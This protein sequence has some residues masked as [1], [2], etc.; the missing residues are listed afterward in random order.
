VA[1][2]I[3]VLMLLTLSIKAQGNNTWWKH[4]TLITSGI[5]A[6]VADGQREVIVHNKWAYRHRHPNARESWWNPDSTWKRQNQRGWVVSGP[7]AFTQDKYHLNQ[8]IRTTMFSIQTGM[9]VSLSLDEFKK[10]GKLKAGRVALY[11]LESQASY[12]LAKGITHHYYDVWN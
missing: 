6:G 5:I 10:N 3:A 7:L 12:W 9:V 8:A 2:T 4:A 1:A 11:I